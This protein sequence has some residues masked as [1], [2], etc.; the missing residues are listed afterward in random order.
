MRMNSILIL[1]LALA[2]STMP[3][4]AKEKS[5]KPAAPAKTSDDI[6]TQKKELERVKREVER[7][8]KRLDSLKNAQMRMQKE[9]SAYDERIESQQ[10]VIAR[11]TKAL[12]QVKQEI[13]ATDSQLTDVQQSLD[14]SRKRYVGN[15]RQFY[16]ASRR[17]PQVFTFN[18]NAELAGQRQVVYLNALAK[19]ESGSIASTSQLLNE[20][21]AALEELT[22]RQG[23]ISA[24]KKRQE[25]SFSIEKSK[26][27]KQQKALERLRKKTID[28][29][30][31][32]VTLEQSAK[33]M[34][35][36]MARLETER[37]RKDQ[38]KTSRADGPSV[39]A[40]LKGR[41]HMPLRGKITGSFGNQVDPTTHLKSF[42]PGITVQARA[43]NVVSAVAAGTIA[44][45]GYL[46]GYGDFVIINHDNQYYS[47]YAGLDRIAVS[48][49]QYIAERTALGVAGE[50]GIVRF[51]LRKG[52][53]PLDPLVW[54]DVDE[55]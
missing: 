40:T 44:Y 12:R 49:G 17:Q 36:I 28:E 33:E 52:R 46:R 34:E 37:L 30:D 3:A 8:H 5:K 22:S 16:L 9:I 53:E 18:P 25:S 54:I 31:K 21:V 14:S 13:A 7:G 47:T 35:K 26:K 15:L 24:L 32:L 11:L 48:E 50:D 6:V 19:Y 27:G 38:K 51:E 29:A 42:S 4:V 39:F 55:Y 23:E 2:L 41:L 10:K 45:A 1:T 20:S 43:G